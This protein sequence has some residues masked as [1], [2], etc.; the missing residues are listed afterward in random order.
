MTQELPR[1]VTMNKSH[2]LS[3]FQFSSLY[4]DNWSTHLID[5]HFII[6]NKA[7]TDICYYCIAWMQRMLQSS[8]EVHKLLSNPI[9]PAVPCQPLKFTI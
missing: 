9:A 2:N 6:F 7:T 4:N 1:L 8:V 3:K 5:F